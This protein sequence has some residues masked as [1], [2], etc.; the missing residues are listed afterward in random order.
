MEPVTKDGRPIHPRTFAVLQVI[1]RQ[2]EARGYVERGSRPNLFVRAYPGVKFYAD[3]GGTREVAIWRDRRP[4]MYWFFQQPSL[5]LDPETRQAMVLIEWRRLAG[6]PKRLSW[7][8]VFGRGG[9]AAEEAALTGEISDIPRMLLPARPWATA[10]RRIPLSP[11]HVGG[12]DALNG[13][14]REV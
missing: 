4:L 10:G 8:L 1:G 3:F 7:E 2:L 5:R 13:V 12:D 6:I 9:N 11:P 14:D